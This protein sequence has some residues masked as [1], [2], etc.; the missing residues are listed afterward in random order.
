[1]GYVGKED[2]RI[3]STHVCYNCLLKE[4]AEELRRVRHHT[5]LRRAVW[6]LQSNE[7]KDPKSFGEVLGKTI[8]K[9]LRWDWGI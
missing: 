8:A 3:P 2:A 9:D 5:M 7:Y 1:M 4:E 6:L